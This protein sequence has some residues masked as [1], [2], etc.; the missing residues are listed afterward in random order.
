MGFY[1]PQSL[2]ADA[3]RH[4][5]V[6]LGPDVNASFPH[7]SLE[8]HGEKGKPAVRN[9]LSTVRA[10][11]QGLAEKIVE[12][13]NTSGVF[14]DLSDLARRVRMS[15][16]QWEALATS[17][18]FACFNA[19]RRATLWSVG[20]AA[21]ER[22]EKIPG[23]VVGLRAPTLP[24]M[25]EIDIAAADVWATGISPDSFPTQFIRDRL[26]ALGVVPAN[27]LT[28]IEQG[29]RVLVGGA[30]TH[31][32]RPTT[33]NGVTFITLEDETGMVNV[34]C[35]EGLWRRYQRIARSSSA[36]LI[37]GIVEHSEGVVVNIL[38]DRLQHLPMRIASRSR[39][40]R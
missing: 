5:V 20:A 9:G 25:D 1:S 33:A 14:A 3:R 37:R 6:V 12:E 21:E 40:F 39:D 27:G 19:D 29:T 23:S 34:I 4:G 30:V 22:P 16:S 2:V 13:R 15:K 11:G 32:Q 31:R 18:A 8:P 17:G 38:A 26:T 7:P 24:G 35:T 36:L 28:E 10:V